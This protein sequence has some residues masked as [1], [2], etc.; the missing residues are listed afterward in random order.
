MIL[1]VSLFSTRSAFIKNTIGYSRPFEPCT[2]LH[3]TQ[4]AVDIDD[5]FVE[6]IDPYSLYI[7]KNFEIDVF[8]DFY[9][10]SFKNVY[11]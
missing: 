10:K 2:V 11:N 1:S 9:V 8:Y 7:D 5:S 4:F 3:F 6:S